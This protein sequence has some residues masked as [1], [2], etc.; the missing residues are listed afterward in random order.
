MIETGG[1]G[2]TAKRGQRR[3]VSAWRWGGVVLPPLALALA[4]AYVAGWYPGSRLTAGRI[5]DAFESNPG[6][7]PGYR[8]N[9]AKGVCI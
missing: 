1:S 8:R 2:A 7:Y 6:S 5:V 4:F 3:G 9:H